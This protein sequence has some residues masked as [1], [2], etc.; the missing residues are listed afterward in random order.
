MH[1]TEDVHWLFNSSEAE[2][3]IEY[4]LSAS[5]FHV[6]QEVY[7]Y[8]ENRFTPFVKHEFDL[9]KVPALSKVE[10]L[11][12]V[13]PSLVAGIPVLVK[14]IGSIDREDHSG[15]LGVL[16]FRLWRA[17]LSDPDRVCEE[18]RGFKAAK[19]YDGEWAELVTSMTMELDL[20]QRA[21]ANN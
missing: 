17:G 9:T 4:W 21:K 6:V 13:D 5:K 7:L 14:E 11:L 2:P 1:A 18:F 3:D 12:N 8:D 15:R 20:A 10:L 16:L 19:W